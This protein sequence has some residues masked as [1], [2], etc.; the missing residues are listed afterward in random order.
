MSLFAMCQA[1]EQSAI[2]TVV[3][4][5]AFPYVDG[6]HVLGLSLSVGSVMWFD[7]RL[8]GATMRTRPVW[9][10]FEDVKPWMVAGFAVMFSTGALL[11]A[12]HASKAYSS[13]YFRAKL[14]FLILAG[15]NAAVYHFTI[16]RRQSIW[17]K[18]FVPPI[19]VR[20]AGLVSLLL[21]FSV[22]ALGRIF[23]YYL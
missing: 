19:P 16:G 21:W 12:A 23:A 5:S 2:S 1:L 6:A 20:V 9:D 10:V 7:L 22:I 15:V 18:A 8:V 14:A 11:F 4:E 17:G 3:R 13:G